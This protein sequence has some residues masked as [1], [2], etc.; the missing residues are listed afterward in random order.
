[1]ETF[2]IW[3]AEKRHVLCVDNRDNKWSFNDYASEY[4]EVG[5]IYTV[6]DV[7]VHSWHTR[8]RVAEIPGRQF[9][10]VHFCEMEHDDNA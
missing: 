4:L 5:K 6:T 8:I 3:N 1:V 10:S 2:D 7:E 9:H